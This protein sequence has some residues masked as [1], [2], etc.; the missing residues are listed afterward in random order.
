MQE[1]LLDG[2]FCE[3]KSKRKKLSVAAD[4]FSLEDYSCTENIKGWIKSWNCQSSL[5]NN[6][7]LNE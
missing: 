7:K 6:V 1:V 3:S 5:H 2:N 4:N